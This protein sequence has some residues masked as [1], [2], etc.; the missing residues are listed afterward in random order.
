MG[1]AC[2]NIRKK[3][4]LCMRDCMDVDKL[5]HIEDVGS[6]KVNLYFKSNWKT[7]PYTAIINT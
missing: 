6:L 5:S 7:N 1:N 2:D 4:F 3:V